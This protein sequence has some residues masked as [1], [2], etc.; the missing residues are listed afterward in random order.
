MSLTNLKTVI[1]DLEKAFIFKAE[2]RVAGTGAI[3]QSA[4]I[5][6][7]ASHTFTLTGLGATLVL[8]KDNLTSAIVN[9]DRSP[10]VNE[11]FY[12]SNY[13]FNPF[14]PP[15]NPQ[16]IHPPP[17]LTGLKTVINDQ[18]GITV[19]AYLGWKGTPTD[20]DHHELKPG[21]SH[22]FDLGSPGVLERQVVISRPGDLVPVYIPLKQGNELIYTSQ[23]HAPK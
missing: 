14:G 2:V 3:I 20:V 17:V 15:V 19:T 10:G 23:V 6:P 8:V 12:A 18:E 13:N 22:T 21:V 5:K 11:A 7:G 16:A 9:F 1:N 4:E